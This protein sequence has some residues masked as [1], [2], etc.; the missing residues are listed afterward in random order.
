MAYKVVKYRLEADGTIPTWLKF[1]VPQGTGGMYPVADAGTASPQDWIMIG[2]ADDGADIS[3][4]IAEISSKSDL[5]TYLTNSAN[6]NDWKDQDSDGNDVTFDAS[7][8]ATKVW[9]DLDTLNG[10]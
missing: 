1:G 4:A 2:I 6:A 5:Q 10:G 8:H 7:A 9:N 3:G